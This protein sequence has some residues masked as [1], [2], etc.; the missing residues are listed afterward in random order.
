MSLFFSLGASS[1]RAVFD[2]GGRFRPS[3]MRAAE[4]PAANFDSVSNHP[5]LAV[6]TDGRDRLDRAFE[7]IERVPRAGGNQFKTFV[8][9]IP[10]NFAYCHS[11]LL[12]RARGNRSAKI[13]D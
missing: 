8:V 6:L 2:V 11:D 4:K 9:V 5:A 1:S 13:S 3:A 10:A 7:A 12:L